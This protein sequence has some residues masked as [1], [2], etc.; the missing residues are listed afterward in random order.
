MEPL[1]LKINEAINGA[2][3]LIVLTFFHLVWLN[4]VDVITPLTRLE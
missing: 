2:F 1:K 4:G 3:R